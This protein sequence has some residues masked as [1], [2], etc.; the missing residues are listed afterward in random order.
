V[1]KGDIK[2]SYYDDTV[3]KWPNFFVGYS[4]DAYI[5]FLKNS[6]LVLEKNGYL[7]ITI[8]GVEFL[9]Y[10]TRIGSSARLRYG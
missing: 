9:Q 5:N 8:L 10:L 4:Y 3:K 1:L 7:L 2:T 6:N